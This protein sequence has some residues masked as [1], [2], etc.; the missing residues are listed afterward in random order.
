MRGDDAALGQI[1]TTACQYV[2]GLRFVFSYLAEDQDGRDQNCRVSFHDPGR[3]ASEL[4]PDGKY[5]A[6]AAAVESR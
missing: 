4:Y 6:A 3:V 1:T 2:V 5:P